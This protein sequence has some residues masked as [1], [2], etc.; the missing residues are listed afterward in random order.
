M[1]SI[2][3]SVG[4]VSGLPIQDLVESLIDAQRAPITRL[5]QR[6][7]VLTNRRTSLLQ[8]SAQL[9]SIRNAANRLNTPNFFLSA[10]AASSDDSVLLPTAKEG[11]AIGDYTFRVK[12]LAASHQLISQG[13]SSLDATPVGAGTFTL[14]SAAGRVNRST[15]LSALHGGAG[16]QVGRIRVTD[17]SGDSAVIDLVAARTIDDVVEAINS[18]S[19][20]RLQARVEGDHLVLDDQS[21]GNG[22]LSISEVGNGRTATDLGILKSVAASSLSG[23]NLV[24]IDSQTPLITLND[25]NGI[26]RRTGLADLDVRLSDG[27]ALQFDLSDNLQ[28]QTRLDLLNNGSGVEDGQFRITDRSGGSA[29]FDLTGATTVQDV[30][31]VIN[32]DSNGVDVTAVISGSGLIVTDHSLADDAT[33][34]N[35]LLIEDVGG[36]TAEDLGIADS[37]SAS[38]LTG[39]D[40]YAV[41]TIGG[42]LRVLNLD[43][44]DGLDAAISSDGLGITLTD[45]TNGPGFILVSQ[46]DTAEDLGL[47]GQ[48]VGNLIPSRRLVA[49]LNSVLA[50][51]LNGGRGIDPADLQITDRAGNSTTVDLSGAQ[52]LDDIIRSINDAPTSVTASVSA[53]GLGI[54]L[55]DTT[56][57]ADVTGNL[58]VAGQTADDLHI[59]VDASVDRVA[60][61]NLQRQ[62]VSEATRLADL[63]NGQGVP[64]G[65]FRITD[66]AGASAVVDLTQGDE[67]TLKDV[68][69]EI[70]SRPTEITA[71]INDNGDGLIL[72]DTAEGAGRLRVTEESG[73]GARALGILG[74]A[75]AGKTFIDGSRET[76]ITIDANDTLNDVLTKIRD[77]GADVNASIINDG[78]SG[79]PFRLSITS[80][81]T[82]RAGEL[83]IDAGRSDLA[84]DTLARARDAIVVLGAEEGDRP[85]VLSSSTNSLDSVV[86]G[87]RLDLVGASDSPVTVSVTRDENAIVEEFQN[88]V[89]N[90]NTVIATLDEAT[91]FDPET[92]VR[93]ILQG[94]STARRVRRSLIN[95]T[96]KTVS[97]FDAALNRL[98][99]VGIT[100]SGGNRLSLDEDKLRNALVD[101]PE[102]VAELFTFEEKDSEG[103]VVKRGLGGIIANEIDRLTDPETGVISLREDAMLATETQIND[104]I[105]R[106]EILLEGRRQRL[107]GQFNAME[108]VIA[109]LQSQQSALAGLSQIPN[110]LG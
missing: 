11:A 70:N 95:L 69:D 4:L 17:R 103:E 23:G 16:V 27:T 55:V 90:F 84:F 65:R 41:D 43:P 58:V 54:Q 87:V 74:R 110:L 37:V 91:D 44:N 89:N 92:E 38:K 82:G 40:I 81:R 109:Q 51:S 31:D 80:T 34:A 10:D 3:S 68:I 99:N 12:N 101:N 62:Y 86:S 52:T 102:A 67:K 98:S 107:F 49:P 42:V 21:G 66:S 8:I 9:L 20:I 15:D 35:D 59:A 19:A 63:N 1:S 105:G 60:G 104:R 75:E 50:R 26:R 56:D 57:P 14:E 100:L 93:G 72:E 25:G 36:T 47:L 64:A 46:S 78:S 39:R 94:D 85:L 71:R 77:G 76:T 53:S 6:L 22:N 79:R 28:A 61:G 97:G 83:A 108:S 2:T 96:N 24:S 29:L 7:G 32:D 33:P 30:I 73:G 88:F 13:F 5:Q 48:T 18:E 106:M 45:T